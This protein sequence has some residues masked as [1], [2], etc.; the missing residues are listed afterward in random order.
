ML[1]H[2]FLRRASEKAGHGVPEVSPQLERALLQ[3][4]WPGNVRELENEANRL[5]A[6]HQ[7][8][9]P[10]TA[11]RLSS[12]VTQ[13]ASAAAAPA[14]LEDQEKELIELHLRLAKGNRTHAAES[15]GISRETL[16]QKLKRYQL[17]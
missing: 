14:S 17:S 13:L 6:T 15:L 1:R 7:P 11:D 5:V 16:R 9:L 12:R 8:G 10:L 4:D 3:Y 2:H